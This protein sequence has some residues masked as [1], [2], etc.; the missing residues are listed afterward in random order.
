MKYLMLLVI[1]TSILTSC[2]N[3][4][5]EYRQGCTDYPFNGWIEDEGAKAVYLL[6][7]SKTKKITFTVKKSVFNQ[8][9]PSGMKFSYKT[10]NEVET[11]T[12]TLNPGEEAY[13]T[14]SDL[15]QSEDKKTILKYK[16]EIVG[17][18]VEKK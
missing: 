14:C 4:K 11:E 12:Y 1:L 7:T 5:L 13:L 8:W 6:N 10:S 16:F 2:S 18:L 15:V 9:D 17:E 3:G